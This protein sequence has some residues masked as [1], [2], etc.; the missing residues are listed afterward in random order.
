MH[1]LSEAPLNDSIMAEGMQ[2]PLWSW[3]VLC[4]D[5]KID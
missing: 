3:L 2:Q 4:D 5:S 1:Q